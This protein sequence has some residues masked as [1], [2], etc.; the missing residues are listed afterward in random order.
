[1]VAQEWIP[2]PDSALYF[3][4]VYFDRNGELIAWLTAQKIRQFPPEY[5]TTSLCRTVENNYI[6]D[7]TRTTYEATFIYLIRRKGKLDI[8]TDCHIIGLFK[9]ET[10]LDLLK[11]VG[12]EVKQMKLEHLYDRFILGEGE[13]PLS[14]F[15]CSKPL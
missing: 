10:W 7:S 2:G 11:E 13:Y 9:L 4:F 12:L 1:M 5:G 15:V 8:H 3:V 6:L 14:I